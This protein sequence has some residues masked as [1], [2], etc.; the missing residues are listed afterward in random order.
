MYNQMLDRIALTFLS[1]EVSFLSRE[2]PKVL[3]V[4]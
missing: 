4:G 3:D 2:V 1:W